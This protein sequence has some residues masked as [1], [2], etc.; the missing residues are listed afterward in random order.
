MMVHVELHLGDDAAEVGNEAAEYARLVHP[1]QHLLGMV[2]RGQH[3][4]EKRIGTR[5]RPDRAID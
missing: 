1:A 4:H 5:I 2:Q 3:F